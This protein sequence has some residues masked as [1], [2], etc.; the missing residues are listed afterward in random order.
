M[1]SIG[2]LLKAAPLTLAIAWA[3]PAL[4]LNPN[5]AEIGINSS[6][7]SMNVTINRGGSGCAPG[8]QWDTTAGGCSGAQVVGSDSTTQVQT[9]NACPTGQ[10]GTVNQQRSCTRNQ[11]GWRLPDGTTA[12]DH[13]DDWSC[14]DWTTTSSTCIASA[15]SVK[16]LKMATMGILE[17][18]DPCGSYVNETAPLITWDTTGNNPATIYTVT[19]FEPLNWLHFWETNQTHTLVSAPGISHRYTSGSGQA[20]YWGDHPTPTWYLRGTATVTA[21]LDGNCS[22]QSVD[23]DSKWFDNWSTYGSC[24]NGGGS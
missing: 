5:S 24:S 1:Y 15:P 22:S 17:I 16:N 7:K 20:N 10:T 18:P 4:A 23:Y 13:Y 19:V 6:I 9:T 8:Q 11:Y 2:H 3:A 14:S 21:C 12:T